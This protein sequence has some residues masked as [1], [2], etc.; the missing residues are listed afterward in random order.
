MDK[1]FE[2]IGSTVSEEPNVLCPYDDNPHYTSFQQRLPV[3]YGLLSLR[4]KSALLSPLKWL[5]NVIQKAKERG[6]SDQADRLLF[7]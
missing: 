1:H 4:L 6:R 2:E 7:A 5:I 3:S